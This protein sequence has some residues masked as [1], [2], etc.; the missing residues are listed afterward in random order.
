[1][2]A[3]HFLTLIHPV[4]NKLYRFALSILSDSIQAEDVVQDVVLKLWEKRKMISNIDNLE[5]WMMRATKNRCIDLLRAK[6]RNH[7]SLETAYHLSSNER[8]PDKTTESKDMMGL[9]HEMMNELTEAQ[10]NAMVLRD[11]EGYS[12]EEIAET[13]EMTLSQVKINIH[14]ARKKMKDQLVKANI[15]GYK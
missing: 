14:R 6:G 9:M 4:K 10:R 5:A 7:E 1:M 2:E 11:I 13:L 15:H 12:Y 3:T 8:G